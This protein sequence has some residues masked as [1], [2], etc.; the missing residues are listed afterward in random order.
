MNSNISLKV[1]VF[2]VAAVCL[3]GMLTLSV[4]AFLSNTTVA[5][6]HFTVGKESSHIEE[7]FDVYDG[8]QKGESYTKDVRVKNDGTVSC[9][10]RM[11]A[12]IQDPYIREMIDVDYNLDYWKKKGNYYYYIS[13]LNPGE[14]TEPLFTKLTANEDI[15]DFKM[16]CCSQSIQADGFSDALS[17]FTSR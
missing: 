6:N 5:E 1:A 14:T 2:S 4:S 12:E 13:V 15:N 7:R 8:F 3:C 11:F 17:A 9:Y 10:V 16:I